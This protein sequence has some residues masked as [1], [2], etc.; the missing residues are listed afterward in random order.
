M[1]FRQIEVFHAIYTIGSISGAARAL[2]VSQPALSKVLQHTEQR[3]G[4]ALFRRVRG[5]LVPTD[6]A[7]ALAIEAAEVFRRLTSLQKAAGKLRFLTD[8]HIRLAV[9]PSLGL[10]VAPLAIARFRTQHPQVTFE[11][12]TLHH[13]DL[14]RALYE[15]SCDIA[16]G[17]D[18]PPHPRLQRRTLADGELEVM[19]REQDMPDVG[20]RVAL[21]ALQDR[22]LIGMTTGGPLGDLFNRELQR[23]EVRVREVVSNQTFYIAAGLTR[24]GAGL[25][26][27]DEFTAR[28]I[29]G[30]GLASRPL[31]P[32]LGFK[33]QCM[34]LEDRP[35]SRLTEGFLTQLVTAL[36]ERGAPAIG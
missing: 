18:A 17:Y 15:R 13:D 26:I 6:E 8:G 10:A 3:L 5:R 20:E 22:D 28:A 30:N 25:S 21:Q 19:F 23:L 35:P 9:V 2:H 16:I 4:I 1:R 29:G 12:Q 11:V 33:V 32:A 36:G 7:H 27:V 24:C 34:F 31:T 14:F